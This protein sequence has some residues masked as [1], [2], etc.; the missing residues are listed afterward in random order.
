MHKKHLVTGFAQ[1]HRGSLQRSRDSLVV[2]NGL[3]CGRERQGKNGR[4]GITGKREEGSPFPLATIP[5]CTIGDYV[6]RECQ[7]ETL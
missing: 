5:G 4:D 1:A 6:N 3:L 2:F 7:L